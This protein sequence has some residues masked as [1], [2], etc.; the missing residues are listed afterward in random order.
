MINFKEVNG[1]EIIFGDH[2][3]TVIDIYIFDGR[4]R[5]G[6]LQIRPRH[7][8][9]NKEKYYFLCDFCIKKKYRSKGYGSKLLG[10]VL[11]KYNDRRIRLDAGSQD[12]SPLSLEATLDF[13]RKF[14][15]RVTRKF[16]YYAEMTVKK[17]GYAEKIERSRL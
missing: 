1:I 7:D 2:Y 10:Y 4:V 17:G 13:Y 9:R 14:G 12:D 3:Q 15:F 6:S 16:S 11:E 8:H 5:V